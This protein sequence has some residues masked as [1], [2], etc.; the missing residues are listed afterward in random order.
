MS[1][2][3][4]VDGFASKMKGHK[5]AFKSARKV[6]ASAFTDDTSK[7]VKSL[8]LK[9]G[10][11]AVVV[12]KAVRSRNGVTKHGDPYVTIDVLITRGPAEGCTYTKFHQITDNEGQKKTPKEQLEYLFKDLQRLGFDTEDMDE[13]DFQDVSEK[14]AKDTPGVKLSLQ[15]NGEYLNAFLNPLEDDG[16]EDVDEDED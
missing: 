5:K 12:G 15:V 1:E 11:K 3:S 4:K 13:D 16:G 8:G 6:Q 14:I 7:I 10:Q 9:Q 2:E